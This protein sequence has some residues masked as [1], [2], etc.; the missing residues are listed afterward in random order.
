ML[1]DDFSNA[2]ATKMTNRLRTS[3]EFVLG[4]ANAMTN[5]CTVSSHAAYDPSQYTNTNPDTKPTKRTTNAK[6]VER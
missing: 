1:M 3:A 6:E 4:Y 5:E 2:R